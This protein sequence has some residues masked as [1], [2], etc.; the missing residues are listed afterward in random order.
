MT[1]CIGAIC[2]NGEAAV[3]AADKMVTFGAPMNLTTQPQS[4]K[5]ISQL[6][7]NS[8]LL[9]SGTIADG[10]AL[11]GRLGFAREDEQPLAKVAEETKNA[12]AALKKSSAEDNILQPLLG[13]NYQQ[14][15][16]L[17]AQS[18]S[19]QILQQVVAMLMQHNLQMDVLVAGVDE[20]GA[21]L[22]VVTHPGV[23]LKVDTT[24]YAAVGNGGLHAMIRMSLGRHEKVASLP[25]TIYNVYEAKKE[26][27]VAPGVG[28]LTDLAVVRRKGVRFADD[29]LL[30]AL[31]KVRKQR[32]PLSEAERKGL[33]EV[34]DEWTKA[35]AD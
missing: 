6:T 10:E 28:D 32:T 34:C 5:K 21:H 18:S 33:K 22:F 30:E 11:V 3:V 19:S 31:D 17:V 24:G 16:T 25:D 23:L 14:F 1:V 15:Q 12:F 7:K 13:A 4:L 27:Q 35:T 29:K 26:S 8:V 2:E 20:S 9:F